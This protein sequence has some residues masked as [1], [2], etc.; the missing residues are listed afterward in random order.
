MQ[1]SRNMQRTNLF[2]I[3]A[4][5]G[6][7]LLGAG[8]SATLPRSTNPGSTPAPAAASQPTAQPTATPRAA[9]APAP[10][11]SKKSFTVNANDNAADLTNIAVKKG[12][13]V[14]I[15]FNVKTDETYHGGLDFR[16]SQI[17]TGTILPG[18]SKT[19]NF[20][21]GSSFNFIPYW[22]ASNIQKPYIIAVVAQ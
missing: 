12:D 10:V 7:L 9:Q 14:S 11:Q 15:T 20:T 19:I 5:S 17:S 13:L 4:V 8:C 1:N 22:P 18:S 3:T 21:A 16:S 6:L 2:T